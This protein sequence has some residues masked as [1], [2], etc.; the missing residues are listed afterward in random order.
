ME[1][2]ETRDALRLI[3][4]APSFSSMLEHVSLAATLNKPLLIVGER[5]T[6]KELVASRVHYL[7][8][9]W[10]QQYNT[11]NCGAL[12]DS[13]IESELFG[14]EAGAF[15]GAN[16]RHAGL[17]ERSHGGT[18]FMDELAT[19]S[20]R[21][22]EQLLRVIEYGEFQR[23][24]GSETLHTDL[25]LVAATNEDLPSLARSGKFRHD[26]L[27]RLSFDVIT[28]PPLR[29]RLEDIPLLAEH[30]ANGMSRELEREFFA[31]FADE[32]MDKMLEYQWP[33]NV[34]ELKNTVERSV[35]RHQQTDEVL[36]EIV[37]DPFDSPYRPLAARQD[38]IDEGEPAPADTPPKPPILSA[39]FKLRDHLEE[40]ERNYIAQALEMEKH[41]QRKAAERL[42]LSYH[43]IRASLRK[44]PELT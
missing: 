38:A 19:T 8:G 20:A 23:I 13:L 37:F 22:Q 44:F 1:N 31:G 15:T 29:E 21:V 2:T 27:D 9:R 24:G 14:H 10:E 30:F 28:L 7:S 39:G 3:G 36:S 33:G 25:R 43:Q 34:R 26:L 12:S 40:Q 18:L 32:V 11:L 4:S 41:N 6:G 35:Y 16:K 17:F 5:G 42:G